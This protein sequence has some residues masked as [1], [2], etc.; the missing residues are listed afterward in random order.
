MRVVGLAVEEDLAARE[1]VHLLLQRLQRL[2]L[3]RELVVGACGLRAPIGFTEAQAPEPRS[4]PRRAWRAGGGERVAVAVELA[5]EDGQANRDCTA[6]HHAAQDA[7]TR[8]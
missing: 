5:I 7:A 8:C 4:E 3:D 6:G 1:Q 2:Q